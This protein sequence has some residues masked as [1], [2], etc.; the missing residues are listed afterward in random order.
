MKT[1]IIK[2]DPTPLA[3]PRMGQKRM[4]DSQKNIKLIASID[5]ASQHN[6][7]P[8]IEGPIQID[9]TFYM[10][11]PESISAKRRLALHGQ[12]HIFKPDLDNLVKFARRCL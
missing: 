4:Y 5:I 8:L 11:T 7:A 6:N 12:P 2:G 1:Y 9:I 3:R 10:K